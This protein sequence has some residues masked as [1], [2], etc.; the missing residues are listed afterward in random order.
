MAS[1][2]LLIVITIILLWFCAFHFYLIAQGTTT[3]ERTKRSASIKFLYI[4]KKS[5]TDYIQ[6]ERLKLEKESNG[7]DVSNESNVSNESKTINGSG[8]NQVNNVIYNKNITLTD[9]EIKTF[10]K[11]LFKGKLSYESIIYNI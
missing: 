10:Y 11:K 8:E 4:I 1:I 2:F 6:E 3:N 5:I 7:R 9:D